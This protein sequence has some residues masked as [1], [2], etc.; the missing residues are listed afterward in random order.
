[1]HLNFFLL[2]IQP[3][4]ATFLFFLFLTLAGTLITGSIMKVLAGLI[5]RKDERGMEKSDPLLTGQKVNAIALTY[6]IKKDSF[7][8][9]LTSMHPKSV[10]LLKNWLRFD[11]V[12]MFF[13]Y[14]FLFLLCLGISQYAIAG[15]DSYQDVL[16]IAKWLAIITWVLDML[17]NYFA[18]RSIKK[19]TDSNVLLMRLFSASKWTTALAYTLL[20]LFAIYYVVSSGI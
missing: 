15:T 10:V 2:W 3:P 11:Y 13:L 8:N 7:D 19:S 16:D 6:K 18:L 1:M 9:T 14:P 17:E 4:S 12:F 5:R 20:M